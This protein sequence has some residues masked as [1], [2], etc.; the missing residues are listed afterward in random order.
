MYTFPNTRRFN[1]CRSVLFEAIYQSIRD[2]STTDS[3]LV[4]F[5][6]KNVERVTQQLFGSLNGIAGIRDDDKVHSDISAF[7]KDIGLFSLRI[8]SQQ[9]HVL[10]HSCQSR[11]VLESGDWFT[12]DGDKLPANTQVDI[13]VQP[14]LGRVGDG[15]TDVSSEKVIVKGEIVSSQ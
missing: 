5:F 12:E 15:S 2:V 4:T 13:M 1:I 3:H 11:E 14:C 9:A 8:A 7:V 6:N 10:F